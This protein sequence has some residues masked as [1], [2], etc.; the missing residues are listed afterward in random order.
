[1]ALGEAVKLMNGKRV[2]V[3]ASPM[4]SN[5]ALYLLSIVI[6][7]TGGAGAFRVPS[8]PE[9]PLAGVEDLALRADRAANVRGAELLG[10]TRRDRPLD[11][12]GAGRVLAHQLLVG[13]TRSE[14]HTSELQSP[15]N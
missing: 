9:A 14:E 3:L 12:L 1:R 7:R 13:T 4:L 11:G 6:E 5:E 2:F 8:G 10:F 15:C